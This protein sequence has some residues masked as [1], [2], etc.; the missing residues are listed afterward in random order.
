MTQFGYANASFGSAGRP[1]RYRFAQ[2]GQP[3][4]RSCFLSQTRRQQRPAECVKG[5]R[6]DNAV[7]ESFF[8]TLKQRHEL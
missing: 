5:S 3:I 7:V 6:Y 1:G 8:E 2:S 4:R